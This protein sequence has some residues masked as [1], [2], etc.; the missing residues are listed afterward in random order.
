M[1]GACVALCLISRAASQVFSSAVCLVRIGGPNTIAGRSFH[2]PLSSFTIPCSPLT[3]ETLGDVGEVPL[4]SSVSFVDM[5]L[6]RGQSVYCSASVSRG[7]DVLTA[8]A[9]SLCIASNGWLM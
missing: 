2:I 7:K 6:R 9:V 3:S 4:P 1:G 5:F 8:Y